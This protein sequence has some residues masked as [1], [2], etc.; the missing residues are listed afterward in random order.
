[1]INFD[2]DSLMLN[3]YEKALLRSGADDELLRSIL[4]GS[5]KVT[6]LSFSGDDEKT[7]TIWQIGADVI[8]PLYTTLVWWILKKAEQDGI[9]R[10]YFM[11]RDGH[12]LYQIAQLFKEAWN[13]D[14]DFR[15]FHVS[16]Q[17]LFYPSIVDVDQ[18]DAK[19]FTW[20]I[21]SDLTPAI[22]L[23]RLS[24]K[25]EDVQAELSSFG[26]EDIL[27]KMSFL[28]KVS[29]LKFFQAPRVKEMILA[30]SSQLNANAI[31]YLK[32]EGFADGI[33][34]AVVDLGWAALSQY[35]LS[36][37]LDKNNCRPAKG[38]KGYYLGLNGLFCAYKND[39]ADAFMFNPVNYLFRTG[40]VQYE[41]LEI[42]A[43]TDQGRT[44][45]YEHRDGF[46]KPV[47]ASSDISGKWPVDIQTDSAL[48]FAR[49]F[50]SILPSSY[51]AYLPDQKASCVFHMFCNYPS[52]AEADVYGDYVHGADIE[53]KN[54]HEIAPKT[55]VGGLI[56]V[57]TG[58]Y[59]VQGCIIRS[60]M[61][62]KHMFVVVF[63][64]IN[65]FRHVLLSF[66]F[67]YVFDPKKETQ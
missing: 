14:V 7:Q 51:Q 22:I 19:W 3:R 20:N 65:V 37:L 53:G 62:F 21:F 33:P 52:S 59:W 29:F 32:Q 26:A 61:I 55:G 23:D 58:Y 44:I 1:M 2:R 67:K 27:C 36:R 66:V 48:S 5:A 63:L 10:L 11:A 64:L 25:A 42:F 16:R 41:L 35:A 9:K 17:S 54:G 8:G 57:L 50:L 15:Y 46:I 6:R 34:Y 60:N 38:I 18:M 13:L 47:L 56:K 24:I 49:N 4:A 28:E 30:R 39:T 31:G 45:A 43:A 40:L 12:V